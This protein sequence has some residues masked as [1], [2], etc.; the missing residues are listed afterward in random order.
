MSQW[1]HVNAHIRVDAIPEYHKGFDLG[2]K[3]VAP[4]DINDDVG[5]KKFGEDFENCTVPCGS[6]GSL[7]YRVDI[8]GSGLV[9]ANVA[10]WGDLRDYDNEE[11]IKEWLIKNFQNEMIRSSLIEI[12]VEY[13]QSNIYT[14]EYNEELE[15]NE[16]VLLYSI[17]KD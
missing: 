9:F 3:A 15:K 7:D 10:I 12:Y 1:T 17:Y 14:F 8:V 4:I 2:K 16:L 6:E 5:Y 13:K 11:E